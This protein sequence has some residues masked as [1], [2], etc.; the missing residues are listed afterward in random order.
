MQSMFSTGSYGTSHPLIGAGLDTSEGRS[1]VRERLALLGKTVALISLGMLVVFFVMHAA[2]E[3]LPPEAFV[4]SRR[5]LARFGGVVTMGLLWLVATRGDSSLRTLGIIDAVSLIVTCVFFALMIESTPG[6]YRIGVLA[7]TICVIARAIVVPSSPR[8]TMILSSLAMLPVLAA[9]L[10]FLAPH[11]VADDRP[12][13]PH[14]SA[15]IVVGVTVLLWSAAAVVVA[16]VASRV[17]YGLRQQVKEAAELG[18][19]TLEARIG[20]GGMG[21][22]WRAR[23]RMLIRPAAVKLIRPEIAAKA[24]HELLMRRFE[25]E[26]RATSA[27]SSPHT[28]QLFDFGVAADGTLYYVMELLEGFNLEQLV[29]RF[30]PQTA[31]RVVYILGQLCSSLAEAHRNGLVHRDIKPANVFLTRPDGAADFVKVVDFGLVK[32]DS[33]EPQKDEP[34]LT[35]TGM[36]VGTPAFMAPEVIA[37]AEKTDHRLD[38]YSVGCVAFWLL[39]GR[40]VFEGNSMT[41][42][43]DHL[44]TPPPRPSS[45]VEL[46]IPRELDELILACLE[47]QP[48]DR[49][50]SAAAVIERLQAIPLT[51]AWTLERAERWWATYARDVGVRQSAADLLVGKDSGSRGKLHTPQPAGA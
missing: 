29:M 37:G 34:K 9:S 27:L 51:T 26:A 33:L 28:V 10:V 25:R 50:A 22:V 13:L 47:K 19:Y 16:W 6:G 42:I 35:V 40:L 23:H 20:S 46:P 8:R 21:E 11:F 1:F 32:V 24:D 44:R 31:E 43:A 15:M 7:A 39:T 38:L 17:I 4:H 14:G 5:M 45:R 18:A 36:S 48:A 30:G 41:V 49:P 12:P 3:T 2:L